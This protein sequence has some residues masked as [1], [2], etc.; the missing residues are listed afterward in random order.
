MAHQTKNTL[1]MN[2]I[3]FAPTNKVEKYHDEMKDL[4]KN[5]FGHDIDGIFVSN[6]SSLYD[7]LGVADDVKT[8]KGIVKKVNKLYGLNIS[9][10]KDKPLV[11]VIK[12]ML[13]NN[14]FCFS[15]K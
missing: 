10:V 4:V 11:D 15:K 6:K 13:K 7:F 5:L 12:F 3:I 2:K 8:I 1:N 9:S 14:H